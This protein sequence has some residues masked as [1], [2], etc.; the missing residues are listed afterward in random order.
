MKSAKTASQQQYA[1]LQDLTVDNLAR[2]VSAQ[3]FDFGRDSAVAQHLVQRTLS[4]LQDEESAHGVRRVPPFTLRL[5]YKHRSLEV[6]LLDAELVGR[7]AAGEP[8]GQL[9]RGRREAVFK[10]LL[11]IDPAASMDEVRRLLAPSQLLAAGGRLPRSDGAG[12]IAIADIN[13][14]RADLARLRTTLAVPDTL[15]PAPEQLVPPPESV[16]GRLSPS[17]E[18]EG[19][20]PEMARSFI[21]HLVAL[22]E[23]FCPRLDELEPGQLVAIALDATDRRMSLKT[24]YRRQV[25][26]RLTLLREDEVAQL[27][28]VGPWDRS[29]VDGVLSRRVARLLTEAY[30]QGGLL[31]LTLVGLLTHNSPGRVSRLV[32][33]FEARH[34]LILPTPGTIHDAG[35]KL[36]HKAAIV[37]LHLQGLECKDIARDTMHCEEAVGR[38]IDDFE[39]VLIAQAHGLPAALLPR[40]L[41]LGAHV[42]AQYEELIREHIGGL[43]DVS[44]LLV[45]R[46]IDV[47]EQAA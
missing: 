27:E 22:R 28:R 43:D 36:T 24:R 15:L 38:Y 6:P 47:E 26:V 2:Q 46:G 17:I 45:Q 23:R 19:R 40:V 39:R 25:P 21:S 42:V 12:A 3:R 8:F 32:N 30:C 16:V 37:R 4:V 41:K 14:C 5:S 34:G 9:L 11:A 44:A 10:E 18:S 20:S 7:L 35:S 33:E 31:S 1:S 13:A 29:A